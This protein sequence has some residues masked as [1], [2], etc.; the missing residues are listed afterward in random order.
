M[1]R[2]C[3]YAVPTRGSDKLD[4]GS[5]LKSEVIS[6]GEQA[7]KTLLRMFVP[8]FANLTHVALAHP[9]ISRIVLV[10]WLI[11]SDCY[12]F[13]VGFRGFADGILSGCLMWPAQ[14]T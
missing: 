6:K 2:S 12:V 7:T 13:E 8:D 1:A 14:A 5:A 4:A 9:A 10:N 3:L 11:R